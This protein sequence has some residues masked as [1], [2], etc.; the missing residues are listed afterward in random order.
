MGRRWYVV[1]TRWAA[2]A[3]A[4]V[5]IAKLGIPV[6]I[7][8]AYTTRKE[9]KWMVPVSDGPLFPR[10]IFA[11]FNVRDP[12]SRWPEIYKCRG[13]VRVLGSHPTNPKPVPYRLIRAIRQRE[14][15]PGK[16]RVE[17]KFKTGQRVRAT[18][19]PF[20]SFEG[21]CKVSAKDRVKVL[22]SLFGRETAVEFDDHDLEAA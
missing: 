4:G 11:A 18:A 21:I 13:A 17:A 20:Q 19:G 10:Y 16:R 7:P 22:L 15:P 6:L 8:M 1:R 12:A 14:R 5:E 3:Q 9:G 2:E